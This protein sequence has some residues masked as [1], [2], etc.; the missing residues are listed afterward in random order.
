MIIQPEQASDA[1]RYP[2]NFNFVVFIDFP[3]HIKCKYSYLRWVVDHSSHKTPSSVEEAPGEVSMPDRIDH[4]EL[5][6]G[7]VD[8]ANVPEANRTAGKKQRNV[9]LYS[10]PVPLFPICVFVCKN[11]TC[12]AKEVRGE[13]KEKKIFA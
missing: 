13:K 9:T 11:C 7:T 8:A 2:R 4:G 6:G 5:I 12:K 3:I 10:S 1:V